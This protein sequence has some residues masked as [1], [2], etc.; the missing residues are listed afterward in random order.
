MG[1]VAQPETHLQSSEA[2]KRIF[3]RRFTVQRQLTANRS[4]TPTCFASEAEEC[5]QAIRNPSLDST[6]K[7]RALCLLVNHAAMLNPGEAGFECAGVAL[8]I[9]LCAWLLPE[10]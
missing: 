6:E 8:K 5:Q 9:A 4:L 3:A 7:K 1:H 2:L 10:A